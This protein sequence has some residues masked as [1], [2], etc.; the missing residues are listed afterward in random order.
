MPGDRLLVSYIVRLLIRGGE[1]VVRVHDVA[2]GT[3]MELSSYEEL[4]ELFER[5]E[6]EAGSRQPGESSQDGKF[7]R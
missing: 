2:R 4:V 6:E 5:A 7:R 3:G 1:R